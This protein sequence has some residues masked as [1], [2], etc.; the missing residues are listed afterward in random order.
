MSVAVVYSRGL[1]GLDAPLVRVEVHV[2]NGLPAFHIVGLADTEVKEARERVRAALADLRLRVPAQ[3]AHHGEPRA[4][5]PAE[6]DR[7]ASTCRSRSASSPPRGKCPGRA[8][9]ALEFA[10]ELSLAGELRPVR[11]ALAMAL[12]ART[13]DGAR[14]RAAARRAPT[15]RRWSAASTCARR[16]H[17]ARRRA[18][19]P[20]RRRAPTRRGLR[21]PRAAAR[22]AGRA[23]DL[24]DVRGQAARAAR[25]RDRR[26]RRARA[27]CWSA[28]PAPAR[29]CWPRASPACCR[30]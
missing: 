21:G 13:A 20:A 6:G 9:D 11:G 7:A 28:R 16:A 2:A 3:Q 12:A 15:R 1:A 22:R 10:G 25:A 8:L 27:C 19:I 24:A 29:R 18:R 5:R 4:G 26:G 14:V 23:A 17:L 30:R